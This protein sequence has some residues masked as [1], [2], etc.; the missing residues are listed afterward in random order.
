[1]LNEK[2]KV[3]S[4][5]CEDDII[6]FAQELVRIQSYSD[7]EEGMVNAV[8]K[9]MKELDFDE[10]F[11]DSVGNIV[12][13]IG[14]SG[15]VTHFDFHMDTVEVND[16]EDWILPPFSAEIKN[17]KM[18]GRGSVDIKCLCSFYICSRYC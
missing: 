7:H 1:M 9:K 13:K 3:L 10:V 2:I 17:G 11:V 8:E 14:N 12:G 5:R 6:A 15:K 16:A 18:D 4:K